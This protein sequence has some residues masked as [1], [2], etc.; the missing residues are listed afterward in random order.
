MKESLNPSLPLK[1][2]IQVV[3]E[4]PAILW[5]TEKDGSCSYL[6]RQWYEFTGQTE[7]EALGFGWLDATHPEDKERSRVTFVEANN[8]QKPFYAEYRLKTKTGGYRWAIDAGNPRFDENGEFLGYAGTVFDIHDRVVAERNLKDI[9]ERFEKSAAATDLGVWYCDLPFS[10]LIWNKEVKNHFFLPADANV[11]IQLFYEL[12]HPEDREKT[13]VAIQHSIDNH[14]HYDTIYRTVDPKNPAN[15]KH[16]RAM[17]WTDYNDKNEP[18]RFDG[19]TLDVTEQLK[20]EIDLKTAREEAERANSLKSSFLAN[21]SHEIRTPIGAIT[22]FAE[23]L[24]NPGHSE[25]DKQNFTMIIERNSKHLLR[26]IDDILDLSKVEAGKIAFEDSDFNFNEF[27]IDFDAVMSLKSAEKGIQFILKV[28]GQIPEI[29]RG[30]QLRL[31]QILA[32]VAGNA[33][34]FTSK[35]KVIADVYYGSG[36]LRVVIADTGVGI[37]KENIGNLF[38]PFSQA[39]PSL[40]RKF[41]GTGLGLIL[42][43]RLAN[44]FGGDLLLAKSELDVGSTFVVTVQLPES[45][46][47]KMMDFAIAEPDEVLVTPSPE[48][49][50]ILKGITV[51]LVEDSPDN[52]TLV[53]TYLKRTGAKVMTA[54]DGA[55]GSQRA[56]KSLPD[57]VLMDIQMPRMDGHEATRKLRAEG[58]LKP[59]IALTAHAMREERDRCFESG[60]SDYLTKPLQRD[61]LIEVIDENVKKFRDKI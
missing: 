34:K 18:I 8:S 13:R 47:T 35:G 53:S 27:L 38:K 48:E 14:T 60:C 36:V 42:S 41:G 54:K 19:I 24:N 15:I 39:D 21:M 28:H 46:G 12:I 17:G 3:D 40:T 43:K 25:S 4:S 16:I 7:A 10:D 22:G 61:R 2:Q 1:T 45:R 50:G 30:D 57:V 56:M 37:A 33:V 9:Q 51:L 11:T 26:L 23:M 52:R 59:I 58:F 5:I 31:K 49:E 20:R 6:S 32:N 44:H 55:E 29:V